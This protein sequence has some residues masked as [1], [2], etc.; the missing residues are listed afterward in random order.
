MK[1][2][3]GIF[4]LV[5]SLSTFAVQGTINV[6]KTTN[7]EGSL[8]LEIQ[9]KAAKALWNHLSKSGATPHRDGFSGSLLLRGKGI[10]CIDQHSN[11][12]LYCS[13]S[14]TGKEIDL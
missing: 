6:K 2:L 13:L 8:D 1:K 10:I 7:H 9:G 3:I 11:K 14:M 5:T 12:P 4:C